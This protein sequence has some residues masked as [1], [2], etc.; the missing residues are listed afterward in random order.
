MK[1]INLKIR[2]QF[3][4]NIK[5]GNK[6]HEYRLNSPDKSNIKNGDR[7]MLISNQNSKDRVVVSIKGINKYANWE[8]ALKDNWEDDFKGLCS[9]LEEALTICNKF[10]KRE[11]VKEYGIVMFD[12]EP[13]TR[14]LRN[15]RVLL[16]TNIII[17]RESYNNVSFE[18]VNAYK[19]LDKLKAKKLIHPKTKE[20]IKTYQDKS[21]RKNFNIKLDSYEELVPVPNEDETFRA[22]IT[23]SPQNSNSQNDNDILYQVYDGVVDLLLT[24]DR[25]I[26]RKAEQL[27]IRNIVLSVDEYL[28][29][30][31]TEFPDKIEYK[32]L[33]VKKERFGSVNLE[34]SF[35]D[36]LKEDYPGFVDWFNSKNGE[37]AYVFKDDSGVHGFLYVKTEYEGE[38][39]YL[40]VVPHLNDNKKLKVGTFKIDTTLKGFRLG[41]RFIKIIIDN[42][43]A[44]KV[45]EIYVT[46]F[47]NHRNE[48]DSLR[49]LLCKWG[50]YYYG[51]KETNNDKKES[52]FVKSM[53]QYD[54]S[55]SAKYN[56][57]LL[58]PDFD[59]YFLPIDPE[60]H[61][62][63]FPD[64]ILKTEDS[65]LYSKKKGHLYALEKIYVSNTTN[66]GPK[67]GDLVVIYRMGDRYP[68]RYSS[69]CTGLAILEE[70]IFPQT[71]EEYLNVCS[72]KSV[73]GTSEL[74]DFYLTKK[75]RTVI[76]LILYKTYLNKIS[77]DTLISNGLLDFDK[78]PRPLTEIPKSYHKL[79]LKEGE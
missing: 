2:P 57:P 56:F 58:K 60:Y 48:I 66:K 53:K 34:D 41:E 36:T 38:D 76:K 14:K 47:E 49:D 22:V 50:F 68:K 74:K 32:M 1:H 3:L 59:M 16:D 20:E 61:T 37:E 55:Q 71:L 6:K 75:Y 17:Q 10:Y 64:A 39:D 12:I 51:Y 7:I 67:P 13:L 24:N 46:L 65:S 33:S 27:G 23:A 8:D 4:D 18:V 11:Q 15:S 29:V 79:F 45:D 77:L 5:N 30:V 40:K 62:D 31:E 52:V 70:I 26:L 19:W 54:S 73:F 44:N 28:K 9:N 72:N 42:A 25:G 43:V 78:G 63:L 21:Y 35:F 69:V